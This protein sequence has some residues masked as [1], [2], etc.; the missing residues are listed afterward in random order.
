L[1]NH[2]TKTSLT[3]ALQVRRE[4]WAV[5]GTGATLLVCDNAN[6]HKSPFIMIELNAWLRSA[7][8]LPVPT[9]SPEP[10]PCEMVFGY[11]KNS[12]RISRNSNNTF[13]DEINERF[14]VI[15]RRGAARTDS[16][17]TASIN[18]ACCCAC[19]I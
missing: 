9:Y 6:V 17:C 19:T 10:N 16:I 11:V 7:R 2:T 12:L 14:H 15:D 8:C 13:F 5:P 1:N 3:S 4:G 18:K